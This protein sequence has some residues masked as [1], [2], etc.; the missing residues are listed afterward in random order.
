MHHG[1]FRVL[2]VS[3]PVGLVSLPFGVV[4]FI[5]LCF[6]PDSIDAYASMRAY[7]DF[8]RWGGIE[9][10]FAL[11]SA[12]LGWLSVVVAEHCTGVAGFVLLLMILP[13][14]FSSIGGGFALASL[15]VGSFSDAVCDMLV[16]SLVSVVG[17]SVFRAYW[18]NIR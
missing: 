2:S 1:P 16:Y 12:V 11:N 3:W 10:L 15:R 5:L 18:G 4:N 14:C 9:F 6:F 7:T 13:W 17:V 8:S